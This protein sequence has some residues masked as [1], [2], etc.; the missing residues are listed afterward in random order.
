MTP[1]STQRMQAKH[2]FESLQLQHMTHL[3]L[4]FGPVNEI[5]LK[6]LV[7]ALCDA[8]QMQRVLVTALR[9]GS[10]VSWP[11]GLLGLPQRGCYEFCCTSSV[12]MH[13]ILLKLKDEGFVIEESE[14]GILRCKSPAGGSMAGSAP[15]LIDLLK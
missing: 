8:Q 11:R 14:G 13:A 5:T 7:Q 4:K 12:E 10:D 1:D 9:N 3:E 2:W 15:T 6:S